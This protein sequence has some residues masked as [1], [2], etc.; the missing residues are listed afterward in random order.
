MKNWKTLLETLTRQ[1][2]A[3]RLILIG[4]AGLLMLAVAGLLPSADQ[5]DAPQS[6]ESSQ[7]ADRQAYARELE[8]QLQ[9]LIGRMDGAGETLVMV[10]LEE[11]ENYVYV[12]DEKYDE[13]RQ[14]YEKEHVLYST[15]GGSSPLLETTYMP[16]VRGVAILCEGGE[17]ARVVGKIT[18]TVSALLNLGT[19]RISVAKIN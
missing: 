2:S 10:T 9:D 8:A 6:G 5:A 7:A 3:F 13:S 4:A 16:T 1:K 12:T 18:E 17:D 11:G 19:N 15:G 14:N